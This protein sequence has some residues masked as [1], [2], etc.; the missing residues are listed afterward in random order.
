MGVWDNLLTCSLFPTFSSVP[1][2]FCCNCVCNSSYFSL[3][4]AGH[5][6]LFSMAILIFL[7]TAVALILC[8]KKLVPL[9]GIPK[10]RELWFWNL[11]PYYNVLLQ[12]FLWSEHMHRCWNKHWISSA[13]ENDTQGWKLWYFFLSELS[14]SDLGFLWMTSGDT[15]GSTVLMDVTLST[16]LSISKNIGTI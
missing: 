5:F 6:S 8:Q 16:L 4:S 7:N 3:S 2:H 1:T 13:N 14:N 15:W 11:G 9:N 12:I 10:G